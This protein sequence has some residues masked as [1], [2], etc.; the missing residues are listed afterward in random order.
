MYQIST[1]IACHKSI[2]SHQKSETD[3]IQKLNLLPTVI[4]Q[5]GDLIPFRKYFYSDN[6]QIAN[7][8]GSSANY[9]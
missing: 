8:F 4:R 9:C 2:S 6:S 7:N 3:R 5:T 1:Q